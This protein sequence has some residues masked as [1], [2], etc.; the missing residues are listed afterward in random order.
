MR[1]VGWAA[2]QEP[3]AV[4]LHHHRQRPGSRVGRNLYVQSQAVLARRRR[5]R[6]RSGERRLRARGAGQRGLQRLRPG[7][8]R[9][10]RT[11]AQRTERRRGVG[12]RQIRGDAAGRQAAHR[13]VPGL[14]VGARRT[15]RGRRAAAAAG[16]D[17][18]AARNTTTEPM[19]AAAAAIRQ[20]HLLARPSILM[21]TPSGSVKH[22]ADGHAV[23][24]SYSLTVKCHMPNVSSL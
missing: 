13:T 6:R 12:D 14:Y 8:H 10:G 3:A 4:D 1:L 17:P 5:R 19:I 9:R 24:S 21:P 22:S 16:R 2:D 15:R 7:G 20:A 11:P 23:Y 18:P